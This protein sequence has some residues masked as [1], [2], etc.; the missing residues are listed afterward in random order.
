MKKSVILLTMLLFVSSAFAEITLNSDPIQIGQRNFSFSSRDLLYDQ[1]SNPSGDGVIAAQDFVDSSFDVYDC[2]GADDFEVPAGETWNIDEMDVLG[3]YWNG[4]GPGT[5]FG[6]FKIYEDAPGMPGTELFDIPACVVVD[7]GIGNLNITLSPVVTLTEGIYWVAWQYT[8]E[9]A[10]GGQWGW[11]PHT[12]QYGTEFYWINP[13]DGF[14][15]GTDWLSSYT[16]WPAF[17]G[18]DLSFALY[19]TGG[20]GDPGTIE[21]NVAL[22]GGAGNVQ[23]AEVTAGSVTVNPDV[24]GDY[25]IVIGAGTYDVTATLVGYE[26][27]TVTGV[28]V[29]VGLTTPGVDLTLNHIPSTFDPPQ[30]LYVTGGGYATWDP[31]AGGGDLFEGFEGTFP[32]DGWL[33]LNPDGGTGWEPLELG[34]TPLPGW[35]G[36]EATACPDGGNWQAY[37]TWTTGGASSNDQW[38][39]TPQITVQ[40]GDVLDFWMVYYYDSYF[41]YVEVLISTTVQN[42]VSAFDVVVAEIEFLV[43]SPTDW[44]QF[45]YNLTDFVS[46]GTDVYIAFRE[47][48][49]DNLNDGSAISIDNVYV[50]QPTDMTP[51]IPVI[52]QK[53]TC[54]ERAVNYVHIPN[55]HIVNSREL[56]GYNVYLDDMITPVA[57]NIEYLFYQYSGLTIGTEYIAGVSA[58]YDDPGESEII[59]YPFTFTGSEAGDVVIGAIE[60]GNNYPNPFNPSGAGRS[61]VTNIAFSIKEAGN[62]SIE[63][64]NTKGQKIKTLI[65]EDI[66]A[67]DHTIV[68]NGKD[69]NG[70]SVSSGVYL[71]KMRSDGRYTS[72]KKMILLK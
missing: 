41:D 21:G 54:V 35:T 4:A 6:N 38:L 36:G 57:T 25:S 9:F 46:A 72:T 69:D 39:I 71:Y 30:N 13:L 47:V 43:G 23:D 66:T 3:G 28:V 19:G 56:I 42:D 17:A 7:D 59:Q 8:C 64:F 40:D 24:N 27:D 15:S 63:I 67:G 58:V 49:A 2:W 33:K 5:G 53:E 50:G 44:A 32:P 16:M 52:A 11:Q 60:L 22:V 12:D 70:N 31:P 45:T 26:P 1:I 48:V 51:V 10:V 61:P 62:V 18:H 37:C 55:T 20:G 34:T 14:G 65:N 68:W 29:D